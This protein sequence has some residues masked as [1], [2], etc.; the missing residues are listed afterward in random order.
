MDSNSTMGPFCNED[1]VEDI[2]SSKRK[3]V[4]TGAGGSMVARQN[5]THLGQRKKLWFDKNAIA[6]TLSLKCMADTHTKL[7]VAGSV[8]SSRCI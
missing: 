7:L 4:V 8:A 6:D 3:I 1:L 2:E 5:A